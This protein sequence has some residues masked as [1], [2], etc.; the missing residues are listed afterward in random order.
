V[1]EF[2]LDRLRTVG[3]PRT[4]LTGVTVYGGG[5][6][7]FVVSDNGTALYE[8]APGDGESDSESLAVIDFDGTVTD[9]LD[10]IGRIRDVRWS[11]SGRFVAFVNDNRGDRAIYTYDVDLRRAPRQITITFDGFSGG[12]VSSPVWS[13]DESRI[14]FAGVPEGRAD[15]DVFVKGLNDNEPPR[16]IVTG[17]GDQYPEDWPEGDLLLF[18]SSG[19]EGGRGRDAFRLT[20][21]TSPGSQ[22]RLLL[23]SPF[24]LSV[25]RVSPGGDLVAYVSSDGEQPDVYVQAFP[26]GGQ[27]ERI[28]FNGAGG[29]VWSRD[30][31]TIF[32]WVDRTTLMATRIDP[33]PPFAVLPEDTAGTFPFISAR[34]IHPEGDRIV[35]V[36]PLGSDDAE[37]RPKSGRGVLV[38]NWFTELERLLGRER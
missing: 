2:D 1:V 22:T 23:D 7:Q 8:L 32:Y 30:G 4:V 14:A 24:E 11:P 20:D 28:S 17:P 21:P 12:Y 27:P 31:R 9:L 13:P 34:D 19:D 16:P 38:T 18:S 15:T 35:A 10:G 33:G 36:T 3:R 29:P 6:S 26:E 37:A 25:P 5:A